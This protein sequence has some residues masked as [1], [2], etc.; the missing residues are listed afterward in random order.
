[1]N[2]AVAKRACLEESILVV[3]A[4]CPR[5]S[6]KTRLC[7][8]LQAEQIYVAHLQHV[9]IR[10]TVSNM[11][12]LASLNLYR[13]VLEHIRP[14][15]VGMALEA[16]KIL[17]GRGAYLLRFHRAVDVVTVAALNQTFIHPMV[18][19]HFKLRFL[20]EMARIAKVGLGLGEQKIRIAAVMRRVARDA[21]H[22]ILRMFRVDCI[23]VLRATG[24]AS[25]A[26]LVDLFGRMIFKVENR[27]L[28]QRLRCVSVVPVRSLD[29]CR[30]RFRR[31]VAALAAVN[32]VLAG[33]RNAPMASL[34]IAHR[35]VF[36]ALPAELRSR[37]ISGN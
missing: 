8:T 18:K 24:M 16:D 2:L 29:R 12:R 33:K 3:K 30:V 19:R 36:V 7:V 1:M 37:K 11:A 9:R 34:V 10:A 14:L 28:R 21:T 15:L 32:V 20:A 6:A 35:L 22:A 25:Q 17:G 5:S 23:H 4:R 27:V 13:L 31:S 26:A